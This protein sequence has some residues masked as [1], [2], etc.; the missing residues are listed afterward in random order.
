MLGSVPAKAGQVAPVRLVDKPFRMEALGSGDGSGRGGL[1]LV[2]LGFRR[3]GARDGSAIAA[4]PAQQAREHG[5]GAK[6]A[7]I[8]SGFGAKPQTLK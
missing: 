8:E 2:R 6:R 5:P 3:G 1:P 7:S 4:P